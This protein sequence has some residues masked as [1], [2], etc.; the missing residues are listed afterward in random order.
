MVCS[1]NDNSLGLG[2]IAYLQ[3]LIAVTIVLQL[4]SQDVLLPQDVVREMV[5]QTINECDVPQLSG[6]CSKHQISSASNSVKRTCIKYDYQQAEESVFADWVG[7]VPHFPDEQF[8]RT[9]RIKCH[10]V[11]TII[12]HLAQ[13]F[14]LDQDSM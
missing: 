7:E 6:K 5:M 9:F 4:L 1:P 2:M 3:V 12:S 11:E 13:G 8:E 10:M 14:I